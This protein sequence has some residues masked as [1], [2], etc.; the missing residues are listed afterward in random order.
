MSK[1]DPN[2]GSRIGLLDPPDVIRKKIS[3][4]TTDSG[5][6][7]VFDPANKPEISN[8]MSIYAECSGMSLQQIADKYE[9]QM[10]G[11]F[12]KSLAK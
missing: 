11:G 4:A 7:V 2:A 3:R 10:Y 8:L 9:G 5:R 12:K 1:S 6:E